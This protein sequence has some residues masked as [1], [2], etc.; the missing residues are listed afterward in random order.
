M[1]KRG[2]VKK[3]LR[4]V[5]FCILLIVYYLMYKEIYLMRAFLVYSLPSPAALSFGKRLLLDE[6]CGRQLQKPNTFQ[7]IEG[8]LISILFVLYSITSF[9]GAIYYG[10]RL[11][12]KSSKY[13]LMFFAFTILLEFLLL[14]FVHCLRSVIF[15]SLIHISEPTRPY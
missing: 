4:A 10:V 9:G 5:L 7:K 6:S 2:Q 1:V 8:A 3:T 12:T 13:L 15:L 14:P 11:G